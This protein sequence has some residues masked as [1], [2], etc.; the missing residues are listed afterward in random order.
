MVEIFIEICR[1]TDRLIYSKTD[2][3][4][5]G[6]Y[7]FFKKKKIVTPSNLRDRITYVHFLN[8]EPRTWNQE[9]TEEFK[10]LLKIFEKYVNQLKNKHQKIKSAL[11]Q[12]I[13]FI[14]FEKNYIYSPVQCLTKYKNIQVKIT[15]VIF[16]VFFKKKKKHYW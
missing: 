5:K 12:C 3:K 15:L 9:A 4:K 8:L 10:F 1:L 2:F 11:W 13:S 6:M 16:I 14:L 7:S